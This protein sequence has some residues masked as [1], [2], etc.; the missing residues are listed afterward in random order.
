MTQTVIPLFP[1]ATRPDGV[2]N[3]CV[4]AGGRRVADI[5]IEEA[6]E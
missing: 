3:S 4:Y 6:G 2:V 5:G 1:A